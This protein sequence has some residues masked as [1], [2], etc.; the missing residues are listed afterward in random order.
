MCYLHGFF[1]T[2][3]AHFY[4]SYSATFKR[5]AQALNKYS[6]PSFFPHKKFKCQ[7]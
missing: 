4:E 2:A 5:V 6:R 1:Y 3:F 7:L